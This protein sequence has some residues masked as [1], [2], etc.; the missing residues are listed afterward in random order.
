MSCSKVSIFHRLNATVVAA[1][2]LVPDQMETF[3]EPIEISL[4]ATSQSAICCNLLN[5]HG[6]WRPEVTFM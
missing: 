2:A 1:G 6:R 4:G 5:E 3:K